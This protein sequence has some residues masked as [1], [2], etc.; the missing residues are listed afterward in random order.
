MQS[1]PVSAEERLAALLD[2]LVEEKPMPIE[3]RRW[4]LQAFIHFLSHGGAEPLD[5]FLGLSPI[6]AGERSLST[7]LSLLKRDLAL[8]G[9]LENIALN[10]DVTDW[11]RCVRLSKEISRFECDV[12]PIYKSQITPPDEW[13]KWKKSLFDV[14]KVGARV[15][16]T[17]QALY[18]ILKQIREI[19]FRSP[20]VKLLASLTRTGTK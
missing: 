17:P 14:F 1:G 20:T 7:R 18:G 3:I 13:P 8:C 11:T 19:S 2:F 15:P 5:R 10:D 6:N 16:R 12:W 9:V 4:L